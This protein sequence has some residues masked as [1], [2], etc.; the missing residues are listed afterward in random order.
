MLGEA[1]ARIS[2][3]NVPKV[4][5]HQR[6]PSRVGRDVRS[7]QA[8]CNTNIGTCKNWTVVNTVAD[9]KCAVPFVYISR[10][11]A[12]LAAFRNDRRGGRNAVRETIQELID[13]SILVEIPRT[14][15]QSD[16]NSS[17]KMYVIIGDVG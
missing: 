15:A 9:N 5:V 17:G 11:V 6:Y 3:R 14:Q 10:R 2:K 12:N 13:S 1:R 8:H 16:F 7:T 4:I